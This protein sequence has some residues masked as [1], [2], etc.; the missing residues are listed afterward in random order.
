MSWNKLFIDEV[1]LSGIHR[2]LLKKQGE[3]LSKHIKNY[4]SDLS[5][6]SAWLG[7]EGEAWERGPYYIDGL[8]PLAYLLK[9]DELISEADRWIRSI[10][11]SGEDSGFFGPAKNIDWWPRA[12]VLK[13]M[14]SA[15]LATRN[16]DIIIFVIKYLNY[17]LDSIDDIPFG[18]WGYARG[19]EGLEMIDFVS[20]QLDDKKIQTLKT[21]LEENTLDWSEY[22]SNFPY[23][24][25]TDEYLP[26]R[27]FK[28]VKYLANI[29]DSFTK[30]RNKPRKVNKEKI[31]KNRDNK[32]NLVFLKTHGVNIAMALKY[33]T[34]WEN[35]E[36]SMF[37]GLDEV[38]KYHGNATGIFS[39]DEHLNG[40][41]P[42]KGIELCNVV[43]MMYS[44][45][46]TIRITGSIEAC[47][48]LEYYAYNALLATITPDFTAHQYVQQVNQHACD[49]KKHPFFDTDKYANTF[50]IEPNYGCCA[51]NMH[52][53]WPKMMLSA[54]M[55]KEGDIGIFLYV[56]G[57]F[58]V[59]FEEGHVE[60]EIKTN[61]PFSQKVFIKI[62][63][64]TYKDDPKLILR[65]PY[66]SE[67]KIKVNDERTT[68]KDK[69]F[70]ELG[71]LKEQDEINIE[72][73]FKV[74]IIENQDDTISV[75][76]GPLLFSLPIKHE[77]FYIKG[78]KP[79]HDRGYTALEYN[80]V[81]LYVK[82][83]NVILK[84]VNVKENDNSFHDNECS[85]IVAGYDLV[86]EV[87]IDV[88]LIPY[89]F[90]ILRNTHF[91]RRNK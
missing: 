26:Q 1:D 28:V 62:L 2:D 82:E 59:E 20:D 51:A 72:F 45:E 21:K 29:I 33:L 79:F 64:I 24:E 90:T 86:N 23:K 71:S 84:D 8:I 39:S 42:D 9:D 91:K 55:K 35:D 53:G 18:F 3:G 10:L 31:L 83:N 67:T 5:D 41:L 52:Q 6:G 14:V 32:N 60:F 44:M 73:D 80:E 57:K 17:L 70:Y 49:I 25:R 37:K 11:D 85:V 7:G 34:Y 27:L 89:G 77:E 63:E 13:A 22:F 16:E 88:K 19:M 46:E 69:N 4:F 40:V 74:D 81:E 54:V 61:Y 87:D 50:G 78:T 48:R 66:K 58:K 43:E 65:I 75:R 68:V 76:K 12:V 15:N 30:R 47:D 38:L 56:S 36:S